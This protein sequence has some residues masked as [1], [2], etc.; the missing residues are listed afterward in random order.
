MKGFQR[1]FLLFAA[2]CLALSAVS[3]FSSIK[4]QQVSPT[5]ASEGSYVLKCDGDTICVYSDSACME[6]IGTLNV[7]TSDLPPEDRQLLECGLLIENEQQ[8]LSLIEDY[9]G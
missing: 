5:A 2:I 4:A 7:R 6:R 3:L 9:T 8:L 1:L